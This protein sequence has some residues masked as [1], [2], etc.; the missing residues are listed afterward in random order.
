MILKMSGGS[1]PIPSRFK[2]TRAKKMN[3]NL[4][5]TRALLKM[6]GKTVKKHFDNINL[7][8]DAWVYN[9]SR[10]LWEFHGPNNFYWHGRASTAYEARYKGWMAWLETKGVDLDE[11]EELRDKNV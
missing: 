8:K 9:C 11:E 5:F 2:K 10:G 7:M 3:H 4:D 1:P 6:G